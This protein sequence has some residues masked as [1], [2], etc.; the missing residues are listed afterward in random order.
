MSIGVKMAY[1]PTEYK[2]VGEGRY[3]YLTYDLP[4]VMR[5]RD[6]SRKRVVVPK[7]KRVYVSGKLL[8]AKRRGNILVVKYANPVRSFVAVRGTTIYKQ[9]RKIVTETIN[10]SLPSNARNVKLRKSLPRKYK[11]A[12]MDVK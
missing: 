1:K 6:G 3:Y 11:N 4:V 12:L 9:P 5:F 10:V 2:Y 7:V 8:A